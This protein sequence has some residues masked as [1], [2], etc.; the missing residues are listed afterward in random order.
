MHN[1]ACGAWLC[2]KGWPVLYCFQESPYRDSFNWPLPFCRL[3][4]RPLS[5]SQWSRFLCVGGSMR[6]NLFFFVLILQ[7]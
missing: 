4:R 7:E 2:V 1:V 6:I 3:Q 5:L